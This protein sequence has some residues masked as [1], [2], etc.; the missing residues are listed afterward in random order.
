MKDSSLLNSFEG[1]NNDGNRF[2][3]TAANKRRTYDVNDD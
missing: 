2:T 3:T 1:K